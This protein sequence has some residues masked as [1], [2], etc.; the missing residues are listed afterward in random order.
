M[1]ILLAVSDSVTQGSPIP[2]AQ[3]LSMPQLSTSQTVIPHQETVIQA[4]D[5]DQHRWN[6]LSDTTAQQSSDH[7]QQLTTPSS[8]AASREAISVTS[9]AA[10]DEAGRA[11][12]T[13]FV[14]SGQPESLS[15]TGSPPIANATSA[16]GEILEE[17]E[18]DGN[19]V[20]FYP[21]KRPFLNP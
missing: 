18:S 2:A 5:H 10:G 11:L 7:L 14:E 20:P 21:G 15:R 1:D 13:Q 8:A 9:S 3:S 17:R 16:W 6:S 19:R 4:N 12:D